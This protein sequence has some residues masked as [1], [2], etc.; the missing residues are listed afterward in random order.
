M[1][2]DYINWLT[3]PKSWFIPLLIVGITTFPLGVNIGSAANSVN[4]SSSENISS[5]NVLP[6]PMTY[7]EALIYQKKNEVDIKSH[8]Y[9]GK[10]ID[11]NK[12]KFRSFDFLGNTG[13]NNGGNT[14]YADHTFLRLTL[15]Y[16]PEGSDGKPIA[17]IGW[18][19]DL[20]GNPN[21]GYEP[22]KMSIVFN[23]GYI[24]E[25]PLQGWQYQQEFRNGFFSSFWSNT[26]WGSISLN[27]V[28][29]YD[30]SQHGDICAVYVDDG[31][32]NARHFF[33]SG[34]KQVKERAAF[35]RGF[36]HIVKL[37]DINSDTIKQEIAIQQAQKA[38]EEKAKMKEEIKKELQRESLKKEVLNEIETSK[39]V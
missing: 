38:E 23:S 37:L 18:D 8:I 6:I 19:A 27:D 11:G 32:G 10:D 30:I 34:D 39:K 12:K 24:K 16:G 21:N 33:Y 29:L 28:D 36:Y 7:S 9:T 15:S 17:Q 26:F 22:H 14:N 31:A 5:D 3:T 1:L 13:L 4:A 35:T 20:A 2:K 25:L